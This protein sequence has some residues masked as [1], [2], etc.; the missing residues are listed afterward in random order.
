MFTVASLASSSTAARVLRQALAAPRPWVLPLGRG[1]K[2]AV[3]D[4]DAA[5]GDGTVAL[6]RATG[7]KAARLDD[8]RPMIKSH[9]NT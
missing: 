5:T 2:V 1:L 6:I 3:A 8:K 7:F 9:I 4:P